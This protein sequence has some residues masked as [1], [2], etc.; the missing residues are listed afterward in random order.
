[1]KLE[2]I[3][4]V[5]LDLTS[6]RGIP[7]AKRFKYIVAEVSDGNATK[8]VVRAEQD[9]CSHQMLYEVLEWD[10][11]N[12]G[13]KVRCRGGA[14]IERDESAK[15]LTLVGS[16][17]TYGIDKEEETTKRLLSEAFPGYKVENQ[18]SDWRKS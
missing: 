11:V 9:G 18:S 3:A 5:E 13:L 12:A 15:T 2:E 16:S 4:T 8:L 1:M 17:T 7:L 10:L 6:P 14:Y